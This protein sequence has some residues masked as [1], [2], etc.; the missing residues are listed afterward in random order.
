MAS[1]A[2]AFAGN[3]SCPWAEPEMARPTATVA[4]AM[5]RFVPFSRRSDCSMER[6]LCIGA[7]GVARGAVAEDHGVG[8]AGA[9]AGIAAAHD[10]GRA[11]ARG[12]EAGD[13]AAIA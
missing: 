9:G 2:E 8:D 12:I 11:V 4:M 5:A 3:A 6:C 1:A 7:Q 10:R 13:D